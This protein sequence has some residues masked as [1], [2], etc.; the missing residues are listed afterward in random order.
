MSNGDQ[1]S[2]FSTEGVDQAHEYPESIFR[3]QADGWTMT[4]FEGDESYQ[5][6]EDE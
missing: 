4:V 3:D 5:F 1:G 6:T 2:I